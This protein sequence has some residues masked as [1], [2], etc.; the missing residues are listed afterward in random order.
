MGELDYKTLYRLQ[1]DVLKVVFGIEHEFYL[2][3]GTCLSRFYVEKRYSDDLDFF[4]NSSMRFSFA[5]KSVRIALEK[6]FNLK[7][8]IESKDFVRYLIENSLQVDFVNDASP[9]YKTPVLLENGYLIDTIE[10]ILSN[11][12]TAVMGRDNPKDVFDIYLISKF[13]SFDW[14]EILEAAHLKAG[15]EMDDLIIRLKTFPPELLSSIKLVD[16][17]FLDNFE[18]EFSVIIDEIIQ[19][20][21]HTASCKRV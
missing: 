15:F 14:R 21:K 7:I 17:G 3:G 11:K 2:T 12:L 6:A 1:D 9:R 13:Y 8:E 19:G 10:N 4:T 16:S 18:E 5:V 20:S